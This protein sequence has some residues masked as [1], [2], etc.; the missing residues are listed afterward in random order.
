[1]RATVVDGGGLARVLVLVD[2]DLVAGVHVTGAVGEVDD[3]PA[4][5]L[6]GLQRV[7][8]RR[9]GRDDA[10]VGLAV[11]VAHVVGGDAVGIDGVQQAATLAAALLPAGTAAFEHDGRLGGEGRAVDKEA[12]GGAIAAGGAR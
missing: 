1:D 2:R 9:E 8:T 12:V 7:D 3:V 11:P 6:H 4:L 5:G 10:P